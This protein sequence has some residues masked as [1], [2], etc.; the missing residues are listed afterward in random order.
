MD[1]INILLLGGLCETLPALAGQDRDHTEPQVLPIIHAFMTQKNPVMYF[2][3]GSLEV[4]SVAVQSASPGKQAF[5]KELS[6]R[7]REQLLHTVTTTTPLISPQSLEPL[8]RQV[9][10]QRQNLKF[11]GVSQSELVCGAIQHS[12]FPVGTLIIYEK[13]NKQD[14][15]SVAGWNHYLL[16]L[17]C[18]QLYSSS[19]SRNS[20]NLNSV[21]YLALYARGLVKDSISS[22]TGTVHIF[23]A[24]LL[25]RALD[26]DQRLRLPFYSVELLLER[27]FPARNYHF[28][29]PSHLQAGSF[30]QFL[31]VQHVN[32][33]CI[34]LGPK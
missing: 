2:T 16:L 8:Q 26:D 15:D 7:D 27:G 20:Q 13:E 9:P 25:Q 23:G 19:R 21:G 3:Q 28:Q 33:T 24:V 30:D 4:R 34:I 22:W 17:N 1:E 11:Q 32:M 5:Q 10:F 31:P 29:A 6:E 18:I 14:F 12:N